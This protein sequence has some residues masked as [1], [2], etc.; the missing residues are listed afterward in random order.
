MP[1]EFYEA[2]LKR[3][4]RLCKHPNLTPKVIEREYYAANNYT[5]TIHTLFYGIIMITL[6]FSEKTANLLVN[7]Y[8]IYYPGNRWYPRYV[9]EFKT[10]D[11]EDKKATEIALSILALTSK[12]TFF[13][14]LLVKLK[15]LFKSK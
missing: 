15:Q 10:E 4:E 1:I 3:F 8:L 12:P 13:Q 5:I 7:G 11:K 14:K 6:T 2:A 9:Y